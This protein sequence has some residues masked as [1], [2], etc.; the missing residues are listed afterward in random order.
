MLKNLSTDVICRPAGL[1][2]QYV[3]MRA[4]QSSFSRLQLQELKEI[5]D[6]RDSDMRRETMEM[7]REVVAPMF[8]ASE[9]RIFTG[10][11]QFFED[12]IAPIIDNHEDRI[13]RLESH[14]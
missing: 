9:K 12:N 11:A 5:L 7:I 14:S 3:S 13:R 1:V 10:L 2:V 6:V 8:V 4:S